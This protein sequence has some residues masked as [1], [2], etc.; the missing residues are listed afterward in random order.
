MTVRVLCSISVVLVCGTVRGQDAMKLPRLG[1]EV[2]LDG[3]LTD[4]AWAA[5]EPL[6]LV[7]YQPVYAGDMTEQTEIRVGYDDEHIYIS[8]ALFDSVPEGIRGNSLYRDQYSGDDTFAII[9]DPFND[10]ENTLWFFTT[11]NGVRVDLAVSDDARAGFESVNGSWN[12]YWD[13]ATTRDERGWFAEMRIPFSSLGFQADSAS[14][15]MGMTVYRYIARTN[16][17]HIF[18]DIRPDYDMGFAKA[19]QTMEVVLEGVR[20]SKPVYVTPYILAGAGENARLARSGSRYRTDF[21]YPREIGLDVKYNLTSN[22]TLD[23]TANTDFAQVEADDEEVNLTRFSLFFPEKRQ[24]FQERSGIFN[25]NLGGSNRVFNSR[26][27]GLDDDGQ[28]VRILAGTRLTGRAGEWDI[29]IINMQTDESAKLPSENFGVLRL[30]RR[31]INSYSY[32]GLIG[33]SRL[34]ADGSYNVTYGLDGMIRVTGDEYLTLQFV[35]SVDDEVVEAD[36]YRPDDSGALRIEWQRRTVRGLAYELS[37]T[38]VGQD[39]APDVGFQNRTGYYRPGTAA[40]YGWFFAGRSGIRRVSVGATGFSFLRLEDRSIETGEVEVAADLE[41]MSG[42]TFGSDMELVVEDLPDTLSFANGSF[43]PSGRYTFT[44]FGVSYSARDG[45]L[46]RPQIDLSAGSFYDGSVVSAG[47]SPTWNAS[48][49]LELG[50]SVQA[51]S[52]RFPKRD[53][54]FD[55]V[56]SRLRAQVGFDT[57]ASVSAFVQYNSAADLVSANIRFR[58]NFRE[59]QDLWIVYN[60]GVNTSRDRVFPVLPFTA[61]RTV[62]VKYTHTFRL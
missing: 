9:L 61:A 23:L 13:V 40:S 3:S 38:R 57:R 51:V 17:R 44:S 32:A 41:L 21:D 18:P 30:R 24:F 7:M 25:F 46:F 35:Q 48:R 19:S 10:D 26:R 54:E 55:F 20:S 28:E 50:G 6:P 11:P 37:F 33:T 15:V 27:I 1:G 53:Q 58:Y 22:L 59:G 12:T 60:E 49:N 5:I 62:L 56:I 2:H 4:R 36:G 8:G 29:G 31:V 45:A 14:V 52:I 34:G 47:V 16:E 43:V 42:V 39:Y